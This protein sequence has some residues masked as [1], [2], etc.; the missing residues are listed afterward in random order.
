MYPSIKLQS[1]KSGHI[2]RKHP[3]IFSGALVK[4]QILPS[5]GAIVHVLDERDRFLCMG[6]FQDHGSISVR[7]L[8]FGE[9]ELDDHFWVDR[10]TFALK[11]RENY[12]DPST[13][14][15]YRWIHGEGDGLPGLIIDRYNSA[16]V[17]QCHSMGMFLVREQIAQAIEKILGDKIN[18]IY[19]KSK[20]TLP[21]HHP[22]ADGFLKG[23][24]TS[25]IIMEEGIKMDCSWV[26]GQ[27]TGTF[28]DQRDN[29]QLLKKYVQGKSVLDLFC[30]NGGFAL[31]AL[32]GDAAMVTYVDSSV[33]AIEKVALNIGLNGFSEEK[34]RPY[35]RDCL[36][37]LSETTDHYDVMIVDPPAYAKSL[38]KRHN[39]IQG[40]KRLNVAALK[41]VSKEGGIVFTFSCSQV[42]DETLFYNTIVAAAIESGRNV[43]VLHKMTQ[44][45][46][47]PVN[48]FHREG[49]YLKGLVLQ[50][51]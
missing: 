16:C 10:L 42:V 33:K 32:K 4:G 29:R 15:A 12:I 30:N 38:Q 34:T 47:H 36:K 2:Q 13:T 22:D 1:K 26:E 17:I 44:G 23:D 20:D 7:I 50:V 28:L 35:Q 25:T 14:N 49:A 5:D 11:S 3:W 48:I 9:V 24:I 19:C 46:D 6:H 39:A 27:K 40:Y 31:N 37:F 8:S 43:Q 18:V 41:K 51:S 21:G 45:P